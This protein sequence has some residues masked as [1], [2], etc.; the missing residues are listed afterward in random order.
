MGYNLIPLSGCVRDQVMFSAQEC[1]GMLTS[2]AGGL[3]MSFLHSWEKVYCPLCCYSLCETQVSVQVT[4]DRDPAWPHPASESLLTLRASLLTL[5]PDLD[6]EHG[7]GWATSWGGMSVSDMRDGGNT[8]VVCTTPVNFSLAPTKLLH[9]GAVL[10][11]SPFVWH[12]HPKLCPVFWHLFPSFSKK[13]SRA[14][15]RGWQPSV[16]DT[17]DADSSLSDTGQGLN[18][19]MLRPPP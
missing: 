13:N 8:H 14:G 4:P 12:P 16:T 7:M 2:L 11:L 10:A 19:A 18:I 17:D 5:E 3:F 1:W 15:V 6:P 9:F